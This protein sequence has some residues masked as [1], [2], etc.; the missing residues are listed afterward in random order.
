MRNRL[1]E[2]ALE[3][4]DNKITIGKKE[5][6]DID[7]IVDNSNSQ[8]AFHEYANILMLLILEKMMQ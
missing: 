2:I 7:E 3:Q 6:D 4:F 8:E 5:Y 1:D